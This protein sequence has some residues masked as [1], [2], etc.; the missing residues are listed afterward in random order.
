[1]TDCR[2]FADEFIAR[3]G[4]PSDPDLYCIAIM[5]AWTAGF[6]AGTERTVEIFTKKEVAA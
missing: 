4:Q 3:V 1:M 6:C 2:K 5:E